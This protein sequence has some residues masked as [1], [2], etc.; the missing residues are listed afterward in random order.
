MSSPDQYPT[1]PSSPRRGPVPAVLF[2]FLLLSSLASSSS[3]WWCLALV[4]GPLVPSAAAFVLPRPQTTFT[5]TKNHHRPHKTDMIMFRDSL[6]KAARRNSQQS[7]LTRRQVRRSSLLRLLPSSSSSSTTSY[8]SNSN[9]TRKPPS[10]VRSSA[11]FSTVPLAQ[12][13]LHATVVDDDVAA[14][15]IEEGRA[16]HQDVVA[17]ATTDP[18]ALLEGLSSRP[19]TGGNWDPEHPLEW[20][21]R[22]GRRSEEYEERLKSLTKLQPGD[23]GY[24]DVSEIAHPKATIVRTREQAQTVLKALW[25]ADPSIFHACDTEVMDINLSEVGPVGNGYVTCVSMYSGH[26]FDY[27][28]GDG[29]GTTLWIDNLDDA[30]GV[31][32]E[33]KEWFEDSRFL[34]VWHNYG[35]DRHV[36]WNEGIDCQGFGGDTM[37]MARLQ[38]TSRLR[39]GTGLGYSLE[40]LTGE[41][42]SMRK[43]P[44]SELFGVP[45]IRKDGT[46]GSLVDIPPVEVLQ[47]DPRFRAEFIGY[48]CF[49]AQGTWMLHKKLVAKLKK[50]SWLKNGMNLY[51]YYW[52]NM[53]EFGQVLTDMERRGIRVDA[54]D[55]LAKV[56]L[57]ARKD[58]EEHSR[59]FREWAAQQIGTD[60]LAMNP[61]SATQ[62]ATFL[63]GGAVNKKTG[64]ASETQRVFKTA[65]EELPQDALD[66]LERREAI[67]KAKEEGTCGFGQL[68]HNDDT[69]ENSNVAALLSVLQLQIQI[70]IIWTK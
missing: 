37:H 50:M 1:V 8:G 22:F 21:K 52:L 16:L 35:F 41:L 18:P 57:Q 67:A 66:E 12:F 39:A 5:F 10:S 2:W 9:D 33:F 17:S 44:M 27:G 7:L 46:P 69:S 32:Q 64:K 40:A 51:D 26:T 61:A 13:Q 31:L 20:A 45:R 56:E 53:R 47:R 60:G 38:D 49:D 68:R 19:K 14:V 54:K 58:R 65:R 6:W 62:L 63:F 29:P 70:R 43:R 15:T 3:W 11:A 48:S 4:V 25:N 28:L 24:F 59:I 36:M 42:L 34:K 30:H 23:E 55:Y